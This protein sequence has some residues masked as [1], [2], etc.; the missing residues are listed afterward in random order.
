MGATLQRKCYGGIIFVIFTKLFYKRKRSK[1]LFCKNYGQDGRFL[2]IR[3]ENTYFLTYFWAIVDLLSE[4]PEN[5]LLTF[6]R[7]L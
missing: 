5:L 7:L 4:F 3:V 1:E 2:E 6:F